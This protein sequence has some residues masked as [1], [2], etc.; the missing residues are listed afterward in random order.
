MS[1][2]FA[3]KH[4]AVSTVWLPKFAFMSLAIG[5]KADTENT[6]IHAFPIQNS[7]FSLP[8]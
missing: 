8:S 6:H 5:Q 7:S 4:C 1:V 3:I 2:S